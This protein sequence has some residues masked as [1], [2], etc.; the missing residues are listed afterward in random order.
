MDRNAHKAI[1]FSN[2]LRQGETFFAFFSEITLTFRGKSDPVFRKGMQVA[3]SLALPK[4]I[5]IRI[6][7]E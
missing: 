6:N 3:A 5:S 4:N 1:F 7:A 2:S